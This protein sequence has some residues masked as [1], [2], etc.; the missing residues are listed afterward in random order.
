MRTARAA[1]MT[2]EQ[3]AQ[4]ILKKKGVTNPTSEQLDEVQIHAAKEYHAILFLF[5]TDQQRYGKAIEDMENN[6]LNKCN[7]F[8]KP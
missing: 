1:N 3:G 4:A 2:K 8:P 7:P 6:I 5:L